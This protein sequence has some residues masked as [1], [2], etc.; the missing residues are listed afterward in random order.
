MA[1]SA[2]ILHN[3][4]GNLRATG[5][6][7]CTV[8]PLTLKLLL[9][10]T[11]FLKCRIRPEIA[12]RFAKSRQEKIPRAAVNQVHVNHGHGGFSLS[13]RARPAPVGTIAQPA[14]AGV[15]GLVTELSPPNRLKAACA[16][17]RLFELFAFASACLHPGNMTATPSLHYVPAGQDRN[18]GKMG[19]SRRLAGLKRRCLVA[20][21]SRSGSLAALALFSQSHARQVGFGLLKRSSSKRPKQSRHLT[22]RRP[23]GLMASVVKV[24][25]LNCKLGN[26]YG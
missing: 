13:G 10:L 3:N 7:K 6:A 1:H 12:E 15:P 11:D 19:D 23:R 22:R 24:S 8:F 2:L 5:S 25:P 20:L 9:Y 14:R 21:D 4:H 18:V 16:R 26:I 17:Q